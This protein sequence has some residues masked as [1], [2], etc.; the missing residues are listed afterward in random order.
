[1]TKPPPISFVNQTGIKHR[2]F[3][4]VED[5][6]YLGGTKA[7]VIQKNEL[8]GSY[9]YEIKN[10]PQNNFKKIILTALKIATWITLIIPFIMYVAKLALRK[11]NQFELKKSSKIAIIPPMRPGTLRKKEVLVFG[12]I[13]GELDG[14]KENLLHAKIIDERGNFNKDFKD[15]VIQMGDVVDRGPKSKEAWA[16]LQKLQEEAKPNQ[17]IRLLGNHELMLLQKNYRFANY[18]E[19]EKLAKEIKKDILAGKVQLSYFDGMRLFTHAGLRSSIKDTLI[20]EIKEKKKIES[21]ST[22]D[23]TNYMNE[24][25]KEAVKK[26]KYDH[27]IFR[28][29]ESRGGAH[30]IGGPLWEDVSDL[31]KSVHARDI[32][33]VIAH[34][35]P[36]YKD[37]PPIRLTASLRLANVDAGLCD[38]YGG[39]KAYL[40]I[41]K[42]SDLEVLEKIEGIWKNRVLEARRLAS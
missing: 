38:A 14:F 2:I 25:L 4:F 1:M 41:K 13:H 5:Y 19:P 24:L 9:L 42:N 6:F 17:V 26:E 7:F 11:T 23:I 27:P 20:S 30:E 22:Q 37:D 39:Q 15:I 18:L 28:V 21:V 33:Q 29:S 31:M 3:D 8:K 35:P 34:N 36:R 40:K 16:F 10:N 32:P 12:D